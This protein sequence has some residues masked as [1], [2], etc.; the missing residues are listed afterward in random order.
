MKR[1]WKLLATRILGKRIDA[2]LILSE[3]ARKRIEREAG[4]S[5]D[6][7]AGGI[8][9]G[10]IESQATVCVTHASTQGPEAQQS[11]SRFLRDTEYCRAVLREHYY[12]Y[13]VDYVGEWHSHVLPIELLTSGDIDTLVGI[14]QDPDYD[15]P[16]FA[17]VLALVGNVDDEKVELLGYIVTRGGI[18]SVNI[19]DT[20]TVDFPKSK[21]VI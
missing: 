21:G 7:E 18:V 4:S 13:G 16:A 15:F 20:E 19:E 6:K 3:S 8:L 14:I 17:K 11:V 12:R 9:M 2:H 1:L 5:P 10:F